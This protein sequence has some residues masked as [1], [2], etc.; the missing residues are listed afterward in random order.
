VPVHRHRWT[1]GECPDWGEGV[2][3]YASPHGRALIDRWL[4]LLRASWCVDRDR[5]DAVGFPPISSSRLNPRW[6][7]RLSTPRSTR[8][9]GPWATADE[10]YGANTAFR[11]GPRRRRIGYVL[12]VAGDQHLTI[13]DGRVRVD[14]LVAGLPRDTSQHR[15]AGE[16]SKRPPRLGLAWI[17][18]NPGQ[19]C[20]DDDR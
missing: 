1:G 19:S 2:L 11:V 7:P 8:R 15:R 9:C 17:E 3:S 16:G 5:C 18:I 13:D 20:D 14:T 4:Y 12:A 10:V 6:P